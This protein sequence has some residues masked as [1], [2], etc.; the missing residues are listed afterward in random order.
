MPD[1]PAVN[2]QTVL[3][4]D[5]ASKE[6]IDAGV[7]YGR[8]KSRTNPKMKQYVLTNRGGIEII[9][10]AK[11]QEGLSRAVDFLKEKV[12][13]GELVLLVGAQPSAQD[14]VAKVGKE[15]GIPYVANRWL[16][17]TI[18][19]FRVISG[20]IAYW[21]KLQSDRISGALEKYTKKERLTIERELKRLDKLLSGLETLERE[22]DVL[23]V[24]DP[25]VHATAVREANRRHIPVIALASVDSDPDLVAYPVVGNTKSRKSIQ[26][27]VG[28]I[29]AA[30]REGFALR[31]EETAKS[32]KG[33]DEKP[34]TDER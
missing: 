1:E 22:P 26:W 18:T 33:E 2:S 14:E 29:G 21:K 3:Y 4:P 30:M 24:I 6:M 5:E 31:R 34:K 19:N 11:T 12:K 9:D 7:F 10:L 13:N 20:R 15:L 28:K 32:E 25:A 23:L 27:F 16:G 8:S 17:G